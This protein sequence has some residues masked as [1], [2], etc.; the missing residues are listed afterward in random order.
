MSLHQKCVQQPCK[1]KFVDI[2]ILAE[3]SSTPVFSC[4]TS[5][6]HEDKMKTMYFLLRTLPRIKFFVF[7][8][9]LINSKFFNSADVV[10]LNFVYC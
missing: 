5:T 4:N 7:E 9:L 6:K 3:K 2:I 1:K 10:L 8:F